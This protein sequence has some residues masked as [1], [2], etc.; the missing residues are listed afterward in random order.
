MT[1][2]LGKELIYVFC[3]QV[4]FTEALDLVQKRKVYLRKGMAYVPYDDMISILLAVY[5]T[6]LSQALAVR[7]PAYAIL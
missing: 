7:L 3:C 1:E 2:V 5:R 6:H 4:P